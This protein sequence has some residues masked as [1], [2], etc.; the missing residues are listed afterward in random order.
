MEYEK[1]LM[2]A[3]EEATIGILLVSKEGKVVQCNPYLENLFGYEKGALNDV[4][5]EELLPNS[6][7]KK[8]VSYRESYIKKPQPRLMGAQKDLFGMKKDGSLFPVE[9]SLSYSNVGDEMY[10][11]AYVTDDTPRK[12]ILTELKSNKEKLL[13]LNEQLEEKVQLRTT[14]LEETINSLLS[15]NK[16]LEEREAQLE[17]S[18]D[19]EKVLNELK[20]RFVSMAS[21]EFRTPLS[22]ILSSSS[23]IERYE[24]EAQQINRIKHTTRIKSAVKNLTS[25]LNE[26]LSL[27]KIEEGKEKVKIEEIDLEAFC[28]EIL[29]ETHGLLKD[30][31]KINSEVLLDVKL[32]HSDNRILKNVLFNLLSNAIKYTPQG[33][34]IFF[35]LK[36]DGDNNIVFEVEDEGIGIPKEDQEHLFSRFFRASNVEN[37]KGTGLG[38]NIVKKYVELLGGEIFFRSEEGKGSVFVVELTSY[39]KFQTSDS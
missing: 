20:S 21:H 2:T 5:L 17:E 25:I 1:L 15:T 30:G 19:K 23:L 4:M 28:A 36:K 7:R 8:H 11:L 38:L 24:L 29:D 12:E 3:F 31:Q 6:I 22:T 10:A 33:K 18:L 9:I 35:R 37:I 34:Q 13:E 32:F 16:K 14:E 27:S 26:F 39:P